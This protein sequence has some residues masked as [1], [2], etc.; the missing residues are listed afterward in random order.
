MSNRVL[1]SRDHTDNQRPFIVPNRK[2]FNRA[3]G[4][5]LRSAGRDNVFYSKQIYTRV[6]CFMGT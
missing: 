6:R 2:F 5:I 4:E 1:D 3:I